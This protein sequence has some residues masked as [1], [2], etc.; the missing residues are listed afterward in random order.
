[1]L[2]LEIDQHARQTAIS[3][4]GESGNVIKPRRVDADADRNDGEHEVQLEAS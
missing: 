3:L 1:M 4:R 2:Y